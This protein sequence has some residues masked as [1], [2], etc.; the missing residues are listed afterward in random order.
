MGAKKKFRIPYD[1]WKE[2]FDIFEY[3]WNN[4]TI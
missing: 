2:K 4:G 3:R 1:D